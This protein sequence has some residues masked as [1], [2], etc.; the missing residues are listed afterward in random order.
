MGSDFTWVVKG[1]KAF[2]KQWECEHAHSLR[3]AW[4]E[5]GNE[6]PNNFMLP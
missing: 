1:D 3:E 6:A 4:Q 2:E 5:L